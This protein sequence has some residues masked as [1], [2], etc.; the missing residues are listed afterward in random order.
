MAV[1]FLLYIMILCGISLVC[2]TGTSLQ[3]QSEEIVQIPCL[4]GHLQGTLLVP[5]HDQPIPIVLFIAGSGPTDRNGNNPLMTNNSLKMLAEGLASH[6]IAT[7][8]T[9][10]RGIGQSHIDNLREEDM[11]FEDNVI[12][13]L[14]WTQSISRQPWKSITI[15]GHSEGSTIGMLAAKDTLIDKFISL[16]GPGMPA[17]E[18][19]RNQIGS[20]YPKLLPYVDTVLTILEHGDTTS[21]VHPFLLSLFRPSIQPYLISW[22]KYDPPEEIAH[23]HKPILILQGNT[24]LQVDVQDAM[25]LHQAS[26]HSTMQVIDGMN[27]ILKRGPP[28]RVKNLATYKNADL[29]LHPDLIPAIVQFVKD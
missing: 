27:H 28:D 6:G 19:I 7:L 4:E 16:A 15:L 21:E 1:K 26:A 13:V 29:P 20:Q 10:K 23:L 8:R 14:Q 5:D 9:D 17:G 24:D 3:A 18:V 11:R 12:D 2:P 25:R 22:I